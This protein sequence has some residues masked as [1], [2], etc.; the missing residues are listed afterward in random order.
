M[1]LW[2]PHTPEF[3]KVESGEVARS[4]DKD[5]QKELEAVIAKNADKGNSMLYFHVM[6][7]KVPNDHYHYK[8]TIGIS[9]FEPQI[10]RDGLD[11]W[12]YDYKTSKLELLYTL[13]DVRGMKNY[14]K[15]GDDCNPFLMQCIKRFMK[16]ENLSEESLH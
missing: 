8:M 15:Q 5:Y 1:A 7:K 16:Q 2:V 4:I 3:S 6:M 13:P 10:M 12:K 14:I 9:D 11:V